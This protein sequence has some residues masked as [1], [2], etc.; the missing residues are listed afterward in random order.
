MGIRAMED[1]GPGFFKEGNKLAL[2][3]NMSPESD[4]RR[5]NGL[6][7]AWKKKVQMRAKGRKRY[8]TDKDKKFRS[9]RIRLRIT[10]AKEAREIQDIA[11]QSASAAM[12]RLATIVNDPQSLDNVAIAAAAVILDRA[13]GKPNQTNTNVN[14]DANGKTTEVSASELNTRIEAALRRVDEITGRGKQKGKGKEQ[15]ADLRVSYRH[16]GNPERQH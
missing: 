16:P 2:A 9:K 7:A 14:V 6:V 3:T 1:Y 10:V 13:Y 5:K 15:P 4:A 12:E 11:R 8:L